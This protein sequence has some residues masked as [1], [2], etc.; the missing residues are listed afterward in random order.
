MCSAGIRTKRTTAAQSSKSLESG[1]AS[2]N[3]RGRCIRNGRS[4]SILASKWLIYRNG[5]IIGLM[6]PFCGCG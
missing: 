2:R 6:G 1:K 3:V 4:Q 5:E